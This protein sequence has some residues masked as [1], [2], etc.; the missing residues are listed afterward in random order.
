MR[1]AEEGPDPEDLEE[2]ERIKRRG[3]RRRPPV[4]LIVGDE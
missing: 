4:E 2:E 3:V 1:R